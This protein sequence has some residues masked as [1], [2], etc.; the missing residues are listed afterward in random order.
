MGRRV[1]SELHTNLRSGP[2][3]HDHRNYRGPAPS[4]A[5][6]E[7][8]TVGSLKNFGPAEPTSHVD[9]CFVGSTS[10][11]KETG[12]LQSV[13]SGDHSHLRR[14]RHEK[15]VSLIDSIARLKLDRGEQHIGTHFRSA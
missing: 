5:P 9:P 12:V 10:F 4:G 14:P 8:G 13:S 6:L 7:V 3:G 11:G 2:I 1:D 15:P